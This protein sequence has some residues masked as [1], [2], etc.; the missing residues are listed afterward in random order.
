[1]RL[2]TNTE[3]AR[4][5]DV[6]G[7]NDGWH[8]AFYYFAEH[9]RSLS[10]G[11]VN[12]KI[13][14]SYL[15]TNG[16]YINH[17]NPTIRKR[18]A[19]V[20]SRLIHTQ[21]YVQ[22]FQQSYERD[23]QVFDRAALLLCSSL[24]DFADYSEKELVAYFCGPLWIDVERGMAYE[25]EDG[26]STL[27]LNRI[28]HEMCSLFA[29]CEVLALKRGVKPLTLIASSYFHLLTFGCLDLRLVYEIADETQLMALGDAKETVKQGARA[30]LIGYCASE[31][32]AVVD[33]WVLESERPFV[34]GRYTDCDLI[35]TSPRVSRRHCRIIHRDGCWYFEDS[36]SKHG[37][38]I[39]RDG[40]VVYDSDRDGCSPFKLS[41]G[42]RITLA[43]VSNYWFGAL[44]A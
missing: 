28:A 33:W 44:L 20:L 11:H 3:Q 5:F 41:F 7:E 12:H 35:E 42:D 9:V 29:R 36:E 31:E 6:P 10:R 16:H 13:L 26:R 2:G 38:L 17:D 27:N 21:R 8:T 43:G 18:T 14:Y 32:H 34:I 24:C 19:A 23:P 30:C 25:H 39:L 22:D 37:S 40:N 15:G 1:M 4:T